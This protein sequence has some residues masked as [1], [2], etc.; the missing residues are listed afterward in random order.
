MLSE[1]KVCDWQIAQKYISA[2]EMYWKMLAIILV[3][4]WRKSIHF[5]QTHARKT[6]L[7]TSF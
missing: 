3:L 7:T 2:G 5:W 4:V 6:I 1:Q